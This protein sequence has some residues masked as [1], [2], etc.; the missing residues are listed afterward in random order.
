MAKLA[1]KDVVAEFGND[2]CVFRFGGAPVM[3]ARRHGNIYKLETVGDEE[4]HVATTR[5]PSWMVMHACL[6]YIPLK[7]YEELRAVADGLPDVAPDADVS[8]VCA[9]CCMA[10]MRADNYPRDPEK[11][12]KTSQV[13]GLVH[14][15]V[16]GPMETKT[17]GGHSY[18]VAFVDDYSRHV[19]AYFMKKSEVLDKFKLFKATMEK[20]T[21]AKIKR[22]R[23]DNGGE[24]TSKKL[25]AFLGEHGIKHE[26]TVPY[27]PQ[28]NGL[29]ERMNR[30]LVEMARC[31]LYHESI[32]KKWWAEALNTAA[33]IINRIPNA[34]NAKTPFEIVH[35]SRPQRK[36]LKV[37]GE[38]GMRMSPTRSARSSTP[39]RSSAASWATRTVSR[40]TECWTRRPGRF[41][42]SGPSSLSRRRRSVERWTVCK[43]T[44]T[45]KHAPSCQARWSSLR[46]TRS[47][48]GAMRSCPMHHSTR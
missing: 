5:Q 48:V 43:P 38:W 40:D 11:T 32:E 21:D 25:E 14:S 1:A 23:S 3:E 42:S 22:L 19:T 10:K 16:M 35:H 9:G 31:M 44:T 46:S 4:C 13:L 24:Y 27:T 37:F 30:S 20:T 36:N 33:W 45:R 8:D 7:R 47:L 18:V 6:G 12:V 26:K 2:K 15:D 41:A 39:R 17:P 28:Q 34:A 29:A